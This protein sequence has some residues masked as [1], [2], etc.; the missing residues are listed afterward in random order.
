[1]ATSSKGIYKPDIYA[2]SIYAAGIWRGLGPALVGGPYCV[3]AVQ[4]Y[5]LGAV[6]SQGYSPGSV[7]AQGYSPGAVAVQDGCGC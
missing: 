1:M 5:A 3:E 7:A 2:A 4:A 6:A